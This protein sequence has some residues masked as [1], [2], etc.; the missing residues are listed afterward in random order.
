MNIIWKKKDT[1]NK[2]KENNKDDYSI[3]FSDDMS[4]SIDSPTIDS[5][6]TTIKKNKNNIFLDLFN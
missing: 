3:D 6:I 2:I 5:Y 4:I 1:I